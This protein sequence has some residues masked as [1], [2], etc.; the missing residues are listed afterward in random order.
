M[1]FYISIILFVCL[2]A[3]FLT[4]LY[5]NQRNRDKAYLWIIGSV[6]FVL[7][8][9][10]AETVG[11]DYVTYLDFFD[12]CYWLDYDRLLSNDK[13]FSGF[14]KGYMLLNKIVNDIYPYHIAFS[15]VLALLFSFMSC[16]LLKEYVKP[17]W[18]G[19]FL[20]TTLSIYTNSFSM[21]RQ[22]LAMFICWM[23]IRFILKKKLLLFLLFVTIAFY[24]HKTALIFLPL[25]F[26]GKL[27][28]NIKWITVGLLGCYFIG[29]FI[30]SIMGYATIILQANDY[31][32]DGSSGGMMK[33]LFLF[34]SFLFIYLLLKKRNLLENDATIFFVNMLFFML[35]IQSIALHFSILTRITDYFVFSLCVLYPL[36]ITDRLWKKNIVLVK[37]IFILFFLYFFYATNKADLYDV[38]PYQFSRL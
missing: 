17:L 14:E 36:V 25:Y 30:H 29:L 5:S 22:S 11:S 15:F 38:I 18:M 6:L 24:F 32:D 31:L 21:V 37:I 16:H 1:L 35:L 23:S 27:R 10:K 8:C 9:F 19:F 12:K 13:D 4:I 7:Y 2:C 3:G 34:F 28:L 20:L 26:V 33:F